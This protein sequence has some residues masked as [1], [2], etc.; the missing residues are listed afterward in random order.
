MI[1]S[2]IAGF[3]VAIALI[4]VIGAQNA[5]VLRQGLH[6]EHLVPVIVTC[7]V[8]DALL[9]S[10]GIAGLGAAVTGHPTALTVLRW[11]GAAFLLGYAAIAAW[12]AV[13]PGTLTASARRPG[14]LR[15]AILMCLAFTYLNP[16]VY[17][18]TVLLLGAIAHQYPDP[19]FFGAGAALASAAWFTALGAGA[20]RLAPV[21]ARPLAWRILD[22]TV[23]AL[24]TA[25]AGSLV[26]G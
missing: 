3:S 4:A 23:A 25:V 24:M 7:A 18:D 2:T 22:G 6:R 15:A 1:T 14:T 19:W 16:H 20:H 26:A 11:G 21:L 5:F 8:S 13:R 12:R 17:L 10:A 9:I